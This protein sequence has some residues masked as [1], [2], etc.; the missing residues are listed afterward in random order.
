M[1]TQANKVSGGFMDSLGFFGG[2]RRTVYWRWYAKYSSNYIW[3]PVATKHN[4]ELVAGNTD[5]GLFSF[6]GPNGLTVP[7]FVWLLNFNC[8]T[9]GTN[10]ECWVTIYHD[11]DFL[12]SPM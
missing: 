12:V 7:V 6:T 3:S 9:S 11:R 2:A 5:N 1:V 10:D 4:E 8:W